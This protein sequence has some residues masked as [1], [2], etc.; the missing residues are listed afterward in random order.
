MG[1]ALSSIPL[2]SRA[3]GDPEIGDTDQRPEDRGQTVVIQPQPCAK[4]ISLSIIYK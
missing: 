3:K 2:C 4:V 1:G